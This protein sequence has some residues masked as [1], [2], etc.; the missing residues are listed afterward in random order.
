MLRRTL[1]ALKS[2]PQRF[3]RLSNVR[4]LHDEYQY[5]HLVNDIV[6]H[7]E[8]VSGRNG[9]AKTIVGA[10]MHFDLANGTLPLLTTKKVAWKTCLR[11]LLWFIRGQ[12]DNNILRD[13]NVS[14]WNGNASREF[15]DSRGLVDNREG[16][17]GPVYGHQWR[18]FNAAYTTCDA[19]YSGMGVDQLGAVVE[20]LEDPSR[21]SSRRLVVSAWNPCQIDSMA[22]PPCHVI[23]QFN[24]LGNKLHC[25]LYQRSADVGLGVPFN[26]ASYSMLTHLLA[27]HV[28]LEAGEFIHHLGNCH[29]YDDHL[30]LLEE[31]TEREPYPFPTLR[32]RDRRDA[33]DLYEVDDFVVE[34]Y[35]SHES[36]KMDMRQ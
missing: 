24:V 3:V 20:S 9:N 19:D 7:G 26:I 11:E 15:L 36:I 21:R 6:A 22:L 32:F 28:G 14:I 34:G 30:E 29:I 35:E 4:P 12:T 5:L 13:Q 25:S 23:M 1:R 33:L 8:M 18:H 16:D 10:S 17:L 31:Q 2:R 27:H